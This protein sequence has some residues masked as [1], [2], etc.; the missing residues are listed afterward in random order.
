MKFSEKFDITPG[1][2]LFS[3][4]NLKRKKQHEAKMI[5]FRFLSELGKSNSGEPVSKK[6]LTKAIGVSASY[7]T[8]LYRGDKLIN[9]LTLAKLQDAYDITFEI[10]AKANS[11]N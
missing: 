4:Q 9:L 6:E 7:I 5:M 8:Q 2:S 11:E 1:M 10:K 3:M